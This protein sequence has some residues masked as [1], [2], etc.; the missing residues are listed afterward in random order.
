MVLIGV[1]ELDELLKPTIVDRRVACSKLGLEFAYLRRLAID[2]VL[3]FEFLFALHC[4]VTGTTVLAPRLV[5]SELAASFAV[6]HD[7][8][9]KK[10]RKMSQNLSSNQPSMQ[11]QRNMTSRPAALIS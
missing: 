10:E 2:Q 8:R 11:P 4:S 9:S 7:Q 5:T 3:A 6:S 1:A